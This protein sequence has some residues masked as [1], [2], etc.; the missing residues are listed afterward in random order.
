MVLQKKEDTERMT[1]SE[2]KHYKLRMQVL[3][4]LYKNTLL[5]ASSLSKKTHVSLPTVRSVLTN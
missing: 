2:L 3:L 1:I 4:H 5:S